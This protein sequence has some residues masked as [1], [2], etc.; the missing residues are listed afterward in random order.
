MCRYRRCR[1]GRVTGQSLPICHSNLARRSEGGLR[2]IVNVSGVNSLCRTAR[3]SG[4]PP[5]RDTM[6]RRR[7]TKALCIAIVVVWMT[8]CASRESG[9][10]GGE[11]PQASEMPANS[12]VQAPAE[13]RH[14]PVLRWVA[15]RYDPALTARTP[16]AELV[17]SIEQRLTGRRFHDRTEGNVRVR[18][19]E[20]FSLAKGRLSNLDLITLLVLDSVVRESEVVKELLR[21]AA[22]DRKDPTTEY[23]GVLSER[24]ATLFPPHAGE[25][26]GDHAFVASSTM[27][28][29]S[30]DA[31]AHYHFHAQAEEN[32]EYAG[33]SAGDLDYAQRFQR[34]C[35][36]FTSVGRGRLDV[37]V[38]FPNG[39][40]VDL[41]EVRE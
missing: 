9:V 34:H 37:D 14:E 31:L 21:Q 40:V 15:A 38:Y 4:I 17:R 30:E 12:L 11:A 3:L 5:Y 20:S 18:F 23:G 29:A 33:P 36:V 35:V 27:M 13:P 19:N 8:S 28:A 24:G 25:R 7:P 39:M 2:Q 26:P 10:V 6:T 41:G 16:R 1:A 32:A 22:L